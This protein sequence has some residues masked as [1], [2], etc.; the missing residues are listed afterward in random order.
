MASIAAPTPFRASHLIA[1]I[2]VL[3]V[4]LLMIVPLPTFILDLLLSVDIGLAVVLLLTA[5]YVRP[6]RSSRCF[7]RCFCC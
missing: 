7:R 4:V 1:P 5:I 2:A 6:P 3:A